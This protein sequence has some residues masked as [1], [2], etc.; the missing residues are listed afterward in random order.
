MDEPFIY[1]DK[2]RD[3][4]Y[5]S[6]IDTSRDYAVVTRERFYSNGPGHHIVWRYQCNVVN[7]GQRLRHYDVVLRH[8]ETYHDNV[9]HEIPTVVLPLREDEL[10]YTGIW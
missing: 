5:K 3:G 6:E 10:D 8:R 7:C 1:E 2:P 9:P 4:N